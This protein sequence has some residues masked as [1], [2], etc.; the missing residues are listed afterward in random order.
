MQSPIYE[1]YLRLF[2][3]ESQYSDNKRLDLPRPE[4]GTYFPQ[5]AEEVRLV[6]DEPPLPTLDGT[7][8][9]GTAFDLS[10][11]SEEGPSSAQKLFLTKVS[12]LLIC[13]LLH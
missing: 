3:S 6:I 4:Q 1:K 5:E 11:F 7:V 9:N 10:E 2:G 8:F 13:I 12:I